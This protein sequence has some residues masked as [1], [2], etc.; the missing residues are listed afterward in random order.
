MDEKD[1]KMGSTYICPLEAMH[2]LSLTGGVYP[3]VQET[4]Y[5]SGRGVGLAGRVAKPRRREGAGGVW[6]MPWVMCSNHNRQGQG[7]V[8][9]KRE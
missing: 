8:Q 6:E 4:R 2:S 5:E 1:A 7:K 3:E 9:E